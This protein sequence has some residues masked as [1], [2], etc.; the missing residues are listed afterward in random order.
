MGVA[1]VPGV[2]FKKLEPMVVDLG[3]HYSEICTPIHTPYTRVRLH[4]H[5]H[6]HTHTHMYNRHVHST[7]Y[8]YYNYVIM[9]SYSTSCLD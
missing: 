2:T 1:L 3:L 4:A 5:T 6:A 9:Y 8:N 7:I